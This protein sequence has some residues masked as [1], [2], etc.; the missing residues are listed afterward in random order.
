MKNYWET[1][2]TDNAQESHKTPSHL[3]R[4]ELFIFFEVNKAKTETNKTTRNNQSRTKQCPFK[5]LPPSI[6]LIS[7]S[8]KPVNKPASVAQLREFSSA[9]W[10]CLT[11][12]KLKS[13]AHLTRFFIRVNSPWFSLLTHCT[14]FCLLRVSH[15]FHGLCD[16]EAGGFREPCSGPFR[17][18]RGR[19]GS[20]FGSEQRWVGCGIGE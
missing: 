10:T 15:H 6:P 9:D 12:V 11:R 5:F 2:S 7:F 20:G 8:L 13:P 1:K 19:C 4:F 17:G 18:I 16:L 14:C 3:H